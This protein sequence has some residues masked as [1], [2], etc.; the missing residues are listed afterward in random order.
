MQWKRIP[1]GTM[2]L[3]V[4]SLA[5]L[6][7][8]RIRHCHE[9]WWRWQT[10][11]RS[12]TA[13]AV[14]WAGSCSSKWTPSLGASICPWRLGTALKRP[15]KK[16]SG[17]TRVG[18]RLGGE[19]T[20]LPLS[21]NFKIQYVGGPALSYDVYESQYQVSQFTICNEFIIFWEEKKTS[22]VVNFPM[23]EID[24]LNIPTLCS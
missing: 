8:L 14:A 2:K 21:L 5:S 15:K 13:V 16:K 23:L 17:L 3:R 22:G 18:R 24:S 6:S 1:L 19:A 4:C 12:S 20:R 9:L 11:L 7:G 10:R